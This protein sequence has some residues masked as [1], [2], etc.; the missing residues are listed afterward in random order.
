MVTQ[1]YFTTLAQLD[2]EHWS[3]KPGVG[4][5]NRSGGAKLLGVSLV[6]PKALD[7]DSMI[8]GSNPVP[9]ANYSRV[10][11]RKS[12]RLISDRSTFR[13]CPW[14]PIMNNYFQRYSKCLNNTRCALRLACCP[15][16]QKNSL[17]FFQK[18]SFLIASE[19]IK[20]YCSF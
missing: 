17:L 8:T 18:S 4:R 20:L 14:L 15:S 13:N 6:W 12:N 16:G 10:A 5:S 11:Q 9:S 2:S 1:F 19:I 3:T 7:F